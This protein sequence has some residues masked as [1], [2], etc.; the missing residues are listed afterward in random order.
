M[1][2]DKKIWRNGPSP[3]GQ[4]CALAAEQTLYSLPA[5]KPYLP[6]DCDAL[7]IRGLSAKDFY[8]TVDGDEQKIESVTSENT[9]LRVRDS[10]GIH[11]EYSMTPSGRWNAADFPVPH[12]VYSGTVDYGLLARNRYDISFV[13]QGASSTGCHKINV[14]VNRRNSIVAARDEYCASESPSDILNGSSLGNQLE[15][16]LTSA[17]PGEIPLALETAVFDSDEGKG[18]VRI[19]L[20]FPPELLHRHWS[21]DWTLEASIGVLGMIYEKSGPAVVRFSDFGCCT[22]YSTGFTFGMQGLKLSNSDDIGK[23]LGVPSASIYLSLS[24]REK[25]L[26]PNRY[27][28]YLDLPPGDYDLKI[29]LGDGEKF[30]RAET[31]L[32]V[33]I[34]DDTKLALSS[35]M[36][37]N[38]YRD[39]H[40]AELEAKAANFAP[41]YVPMVSKG[42]EFSP[43]GKTTFSSSDTLIAY[44]EIYKPQLAS[45]A[46]SGVQVHLKIV[47]AKSGS[48]VKDFP[49][50]DAATYERSGSDVIP[51]A[52]EVPVSEL[53]K[54]QY[55]LEV[56]AT[57]AA[58]RT[59]PWRESDFSIE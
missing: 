3:A 7:Y 43:A 6:P 12:Y 13:P 42:A 48:L 55:R 14:T 47:D 46:E 49:A 18:R 32:K 30:G 15:G 23:Q 44:F 5:T 56:Q 1:V 4:K 27:E 2:A 35:V 8:L 21:Q 38:R 58:G 41:Q 29:V 10:L 9:G 20:E 11:N 19:A 22:Q 51:I 50:V 31:H 57:D 36:L 26:I 34:P 33:E 16:E 53:A 17:Q 59:T 52:R 45:G 39:A 25:S 24:N 37:C 54:G 40:V 28:T